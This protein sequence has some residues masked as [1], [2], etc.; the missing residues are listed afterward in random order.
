MELE[1]HVALV[2]GGT[3]GIGAQVAHLLVREGAQAIISGRDTGRG[4]RA[5]A[6]IACGGGHVRFIAADLGDLDS[7][8]NLADQSGEV[9]ILV[10]NAA[11]F[12][13]GLSADQDVT[14]F[15]NMFDTNVRATYFLT[16][17]LAPAMLAKGRGSIVNVTA[18]GASLGVAGASG[19]SATRAALMSLTR[20]WAAEFSP[21][22]VRVNSVAPGPIRSEGAGVDWG[23]DLARTLPARGH[24]ARAY[25]IAEAILFLASPRARY[26]TGSTLT[27]DSGA[28][29]LTASRSAQPAAPA[30]SDTSAVRLSTPTTSCRT[31]S[32]PSS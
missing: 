31:S 13:T 29:D 23:E 25:E 21:Q 22:G 26:V 8:R 15:Q 17:L 20:T 3:A 19:Y 16:E 5:A 28:T 4:T 6:E 30:A 2:T 24:T 11:G 7:I 14:S 32:G 9:D 1:G 18:M 27:V 10:N 12:P